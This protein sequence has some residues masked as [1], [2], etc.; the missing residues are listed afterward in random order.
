M[1]SLKKNEIFRTLSIRH[2]TIYV[3]NDKFVATK[4]TKMYGYDVLIIISTRQDI[5]DS[6]EIKIICDEFRNQ[7]TILTK[8]V[9]FFEL[10]CKLPF[11]FIYE[12]IITNMRKCFFEIVNC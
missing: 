2:F 4:K 8:I 3:L 10:N 6:M 1:D 12:E 11:W 7:R 5:V 9:S